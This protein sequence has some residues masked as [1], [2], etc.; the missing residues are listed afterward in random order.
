VVVAGIGTT[1]VLE[2]QALVKLR[3]QNRALVQQ[4]EQLSRQAETPPHRSN[5][6]APADH[7]VSLGQKESQ[8][9]NRLRGAIGAL[10]PP[11]NEIAKLRA[12]N[13]QLRSATNE[14]DEPADPAEAEFKKQTQERDNHLKQLGLS[15]RIFASEH[16]DK[17]PDSFEQIA[18]QIDEAHRASFLET[19][20][21]NFEIVFRGMAEG[22][23]GDT[24]VCREKQARRSP[25]G[26]WVKIYG[27]A[28]GT[29]QI[30]TEPEDNFDAY[31]KQHWAG[32]R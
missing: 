8:E 4:V 10:R 11:T 19:A 2:Q 3:A 23:P 28:D 24:I 30:H 7:S 29:T 9:L 25:K 27:Y 20:T 32:T 13:R 18:D 1:L 22:V 21:N 26:E 31:E 12:D 15:F 16:N 17:L 6:V 5:R 14:P